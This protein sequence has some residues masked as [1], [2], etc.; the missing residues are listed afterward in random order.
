M[1]K[2]WAFP[3]QGFEIDACLKADLEEIVLFMPT[4]DL[5]MKILT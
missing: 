3:D 4:S 1:Q 2:L 5:M